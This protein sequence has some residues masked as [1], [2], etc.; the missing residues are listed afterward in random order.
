MS[1]LLILVAQTKGVALIVI[2]SLLLGAAIIS[3][4][5]AWLY[6]KSIYV[7]RIKAIESERDELN[8]QIVIL[9]EAISTLNK[10]HKEKDDEIENLIKEVNDL[11]T[12]K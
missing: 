10:S 11:R 5:T 9:N 6:Y 2:L 3:Y 4:L 1:T 7:R 12:G 8:N